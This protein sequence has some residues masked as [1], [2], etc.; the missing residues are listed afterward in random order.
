[1]CD[2]ELLSS[3]QDVCLKLSHEVLL[4]LKPRKLLY[5]TIY[6]AEVL[7]N[8]VTCW[9]CC[10]VAYKKGF[11]LDDWIYCTLYL[12]NSGLQP[13]TALSLIYTLYS[14]SLPRTTILILH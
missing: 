4:T 9:A 13:I 10:C 6:W 1:M 8:T 12:Y 2:S 14:S 3:F 5:K 7:I 11:G